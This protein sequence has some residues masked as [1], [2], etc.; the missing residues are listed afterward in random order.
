MRAVDG[1]VLFQLLLAAT[2]AAPDRPLDG[3]A[4][5]LHHVAG[6]RCTA[7]GRPVESL[8]V[9]LDDWRYQAWTERGEVAAR[10]VHTV[11]GVVLKR[12]SLP[13]EEWLA[14]LAGHLAEFAQSHRR[15]YDAI[16]ALDH[17]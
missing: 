9:D 4:E 12:Q 1:D 5:D 7:T 14:A 16:V 11:R 17:P 15:V 6:E 3:L 8:Q 10:A 2:A 13:F